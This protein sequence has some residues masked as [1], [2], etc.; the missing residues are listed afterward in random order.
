MHIFERMSFFLIHKASQL[1]RSWVTSVQTVMKHSSSLET[2]TL[3][4]R[5]NT[6][7]KLVWPCEDLV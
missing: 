3:E 5:G 6:H 2:I 4:G 1:N 7:C